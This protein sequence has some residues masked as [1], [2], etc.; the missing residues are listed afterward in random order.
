MIGDLKRSRKRMVLGMALLLACASLIIAAPG[1]SPAQAAATLSTG[2]ASTTW[3]LAEGCTAG[4][5]ETW[6]LVQNPG[7][8]DVTVDLTFMTSTGEK[9]GPQDFTIEAETRHSFNLNAYVTDYDVSTRVVASGDV[10]CERAM[11]GGNRTWAHDSIGVTQPDTTWYL[12]EGC[13][14]GDFETWVLVQNPGA[15]DVT[16]DLTFMTSA[17]MRPGPLGFSIPAGTRH[18]FNLNDYVTD[19]DVSTKVVATGDVV[20]ERAVYGGDRTWAHDSIG[21][22]GADMSQAVTATIPVGDKPQGLGLNPNTNRVYATNQD[23]DDVSVI[24]GATNPV[25]TTIPVGDGPYGVGINPGTNVIYITNQNDDNVSVIDGAT[26]TVTTTVNVGDFPWSLAVNP[27]TNKVY[28]GNWGSDN[29]SVINGATNLV[30]ATVPA[31]DGPSGVAV[32]PLTNKVYVPN[33]NSSSVSVIDGATDTFA[34][35][36]PVGTNPE[37]IGINPVTNMIYVAN[38]GDSTISVIDGATDTLT[39]TITGID[40]PVCI[41]LNPLTGLFYVANILNDSVTVIDSAT[42]EVIDTI[43]VGDAPYGVAVNPSTDTVY[44]ADSDSDDVSVISGP[45]VWYLAEGCTA[46]DFETWVLVQN[47]NSWAVTVDLVLMTDIGMQKPPGL[48]DVT[49]GANSRRSFDLGAYAVTY[50]VST[51]VMSPIGDII[52]ERAMYGG[53]RTWGTDSIGAASAAPTWYLAEGCTAGGFETWVLVQNP[54]MAAVDVDLTF[55]TSTGPVAGPQGV[56]IPAQSRVSFNVG[57]YVTDY[58]VST[59]VT[60]AT[61]VIC[62]RAMYG[63]NRTWAHDS[64]GYPT[65]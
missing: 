15:T 26:N 18:S 23:S 62:E 17:G 5:F 21:A 19:W 53:E 13:T 3:Y 22:S 6:V 51:L 10:V 65:H 55:M 2:M 29:V 44:T 41:G 39:D 63:N 43:P 9:P 45:R 7:A 57:Q 11:Y 32:N 60:C 25:M 4:D 24:D 40:A 34:K 20:C 35:S 56:S 54:S 31:G 37:G 16:V 50:N 47:P 38:S 1:A 14:G 12:A 64:I 61:G 58:N 48:Q 8:T 28:V 36:I 42:N 49:I 59:E 30:T 52:C 27:L 46:G 33:Y